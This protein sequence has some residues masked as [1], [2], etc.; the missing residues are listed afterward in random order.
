MKI[1]L[2]AATANLD[3]N[4]LY[5]LAR[6]ISIEFNHAKVDVAS[7]IEPHRESEFQ[8]TFDRCRNQWNSP[9]ILDWFSE[10]L[11]PDINTK[12]LVILDVDAYSNGLNYVLGE[13]FHKG[14]LATIYLPRLKPEFYGLKP[15]A[16][17]FYERMSKECVHELGHV[18]G[19]VHCPNTE[20]V[21][22]FSNSLSD[23]DTK[24]KSFCATCEIK[25]PIF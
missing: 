13:A 24:G 5:Q 23:T 17:L 3:N 18:F 22:H 16:K 19:F 15:N 10:K 7:G 8:L 1:T 21:M 25:K 14:Q 12:I 4:A 20:C 9:R 11:K 6:D 2:Q